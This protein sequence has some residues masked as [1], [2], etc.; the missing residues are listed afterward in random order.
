MK[1]VLLAIAVALALLTRAHG[2]EFSKVE[3]AGKSFTVC[4]VNVQKEHL[5][6]GPMIGVSQ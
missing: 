2:V 3:F 4:H 5:E 1:R 6:L